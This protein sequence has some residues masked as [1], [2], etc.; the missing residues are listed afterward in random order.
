MMMEV[1]LNIFHT[2][3]IAKDFENIGSWNP[4]MHG[5]QFPDFSKLPEE[6]IWPFPR[7]VTA[8]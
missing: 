5:C 7:M 1:V 8:T 6:Q 2:K 3:K 4:M